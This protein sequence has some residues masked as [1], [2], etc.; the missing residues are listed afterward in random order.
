MDKFTK[1]FGES[2]ILTNVEYLK[3][4]AGQMLAYFSDAIIQ[5]ALITWVISFLPVPGNIMITVLFCFLLPQFLLNIFAGIYVDRFFRKRILVLSTIYRAILVFAVAGIIKI[6]GITTSSVIPVWF[7]YAF[8]FLLGTG[9][10][11]FYPVKMASLTKIVKPEDLK[12][13]SALNIGSVAFAVF[14][15]AVLSEI[16]ITK[17]G[18]FGSFFINGIL[19]LIAAAFFALLAFKK[20]EGYAA[21][22]LS[23]MGDLKFVQR[24]FKTHKRAL[25]FVILSIVLSLVIA[26]FFN[27][28]NALATDYYMRG[29]E[30]LMQFRGIL[31]FGVIFVTGITILL[32]RFLRTYNM[33]AVGFILLFLVMLTSPFCHTINQARFWLIPIGVANAIILVMADTILQKITPDRTRGKIFGLQSTM[34][35]FGFLVGIALI[36]SAAGTIQPLVIFRGISLFC[37]LMALIVLT[38]DKTFR[39]FLLKTI[40]GHIFS[41]L[42]KYK[43]EGLEHL[44]KKGK[45]ILAG[46]H[47]GYFDPLII[48]IATGRQPWFIAGPAAFKVPVIRRI[49]KYFNVIQI[50]PKK[51]ADALDIAKKR[52]QQGQVV[53]VFSEGKLRPRKTLCKFGRSASILAKE[54]DAPIIPF[55]IRSQFE[56]LDKKKKKPRFL[57]RAIIQFGQAIEYENKDEKKITGELQSRVSFMENSLERRFFY[58]IKEKFYNN[59]LD[60]MQEKSD[61]YGPTKALLLK[62]KDH[63]DEMSYIELSRLAKNFANYLIEE[64]KIERND[65]IAILSESRP[66]WGVAMFAS[67]QTGAITVPL[68]IKLTLHELTSILSDCNPRILCVSSSYLDLAVQIK[69]NV[70]SIERIF[71]I[72]NVQSENPEIKNLY[73]IKADIS[74]DL[75]RPRNLDETALIVYT[76]GTVGNPKG[77]MISF[78]NIYS[79]LRDFEAVF[80]YARQSS[81]VSILPLNH[82]LELSVGLFG[83]L[84]MGAKIVYIKTLNPKEI[85]KVMQEIKV[86]NML[87]VPL[88]IKMLKTSIEKEINKQPA[89]KQKV[90]NFMY[91]ISKF[92]PIKARRMIF[93]SIIDQLG[94]HLE[95]FICGGAP[96]DIDV[97]EFFDRIGIPIY[98]GYGLTEASPTVTTNYPKHN[99]LGSVGKPLPS[100]EIKT[101]ESGEILVKGSSIMQGYYGKP[102]LTAE[103]IDEDGWLYTGDIGTIDKQ[104]YLYI[105]G[106]IKNMIVLGGGKKIFPEEVEEVLEHSHLTKEICVMSL[107]IKSGHK[108]G[109][110]EVGAIVVPEDELL[111]KSDEE[112][113][114]L[115]EQDFKILGKNLASYK[116]PTV[117]II[118]RDEMPKTS[119]RKIKRRELLEWYENLK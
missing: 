73:E 7:V 113:K 44:P 2:G 33:L 1:K 82:L 58:N 46:N 31:G 69:E 105:T 26:T 3:F 14:L 68:D 32:A 72:D 25:Y 5:I 22:K 85:A 19:Y 76:S 9:S 28:L 27:T 29:T 38:F 75:G 52:L 104:G 10:A 90:F 65:R 110:E 63:Y 66:Q 89:A 56:T 109:T 96:L 78:A 45:V 67:I 103:A 108:A 39:N 8:S 13:A 93:K 48:Q 12:V 16:Y 100:V 21:D 118:R 18:L 42:F 24:Y 84:Y 98:Q 70:K 15:G 4:F 47:S 81:V 57:N 51:G 97:G 117:V 59:F 54:T 71:I 77:V 106:R 79:Q 86:K 6:T 61:L 91:A 111:E 92:M 74:K 102:E 99:R 37:F 40:L 30:N 115:V 107:K 114:K 88:F 53:A 119:T 17:A 11:F 62:N 101:T 60:L 49:L 43:V 34:A 41:A 95:C 80:E 50:V 87:V 112:I 116:R 64:V 94:G 55:A 36:A 35:T 20:S 83:A 23:I